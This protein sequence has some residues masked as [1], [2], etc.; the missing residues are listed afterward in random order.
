MDPKNRV[1]NNLQN[2]PVLSSAADSGVGTAIEGTFDSAPGTTFTATTP[3]EQNITATATDPDGDTSEFSAPVAVAVVDSTKPTITP[4]SPKPNSKS[5]S[6]TQGEPAKGDIKL[7]LDGRARSF[8]YDP[9]N[10]RLSFTATN[11]SFEKHTIKIVATDAAG[12]ATTRSWSFTVKK[13]KKK[14]R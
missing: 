1:E 12:N 10:D 14:R 4:I 5:F 6:R 9:S 13:K 2:F 3:A 11:L 7:F 8:A